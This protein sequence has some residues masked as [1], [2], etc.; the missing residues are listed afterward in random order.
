MCTRLRAGTDPEWLWPAVDAA[1]DARLVSPAARAVS[2]Q[3]GSQLLRSAASVFDAAWLRSLRGPHHPVAVGAVSAAAGLDPR[4]AAENAAYGALAGGAS[5]GLRLL[6]LDPTG[7]ARVVAA[8]A[9]LV[10]AI[11]DRAALAGRGPLARLD[12]TS[13]PVSDLLAEAHFER[14]E[15]LFAS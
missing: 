7:T 3:Q 15:R 6:G 5:A 1:C 2:R 10:D 4:A 8:L 12:S 9:P 14:R 13:A 11:A